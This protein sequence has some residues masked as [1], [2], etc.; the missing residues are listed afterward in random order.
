[1][2]DLTDWKQK[3][4][5]AH[6]KFKP[7][8]K[9][10]EK[11]LQYYRGIQPL[12]AS[13]TEK[14]VDNMVFSNIRALLP[15][16]NIRNPKIFVRA[17]KKPYQTDKGIFDTIGGSVAW[18]ILLAW[19]YQELKI[20]REARK[21]LVDSFLGP[22]GIMQLGYTVETEKIKSDELLE[23]NELIK[24]DSP[25]VV[26]RSLK[27]FRCDPE[28]TDSSLDDC[29][30]VAFRW[31]K[32]L[33]DLKASGKYSNLKTLRPNYTVKTD[34]ESKTDT[35]Q[36]VANDLWNRVEGWDI[37]DKKKHKIITIVEAHD[38]A[39]NE[40][41]W[42]LELEGFPCETLY[43]NENPDDLFPICDVEMYIPAQD[44][45][46][47]I[48]SLQMDY[49]KNIAQM[50]MVTRENSLNADQLLKLETGGNRTIVETSTNPVDAI[51]PLR[52]PSI[53]QDV[54][55][56]ANIVRKNLLEAAGISEAEKMSG[57]N[58]ET[59]SEPNLINAGVQSVREDQRDIFEDFVKRNIRKL[60]QIV[61][62]TMTE[63]SLPL[64]NE[65]F[66]LAQ[67]HLPTKLD[68][69]IGQENA[70]AIMPFL[71]LSKD[72]LQG[73]YDF[74]IELGSTQPINEQSRKQDAMALYQL[75]ASNPYMKKREGT[76]KLL[77]AFNQMDADDLLKTDE[78]VGQEQAQQAQMAFQ[79]Q[80]AEP[81]L[82]TQTDLQKTDMKTKTTLMGEKMRGDVEMAKMGH[83]HASKME[84]EGLKIKG[85]I[86]AE[87]LKQEKEKKNG[88]GDKD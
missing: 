2:S 62:Q 60:A 71:N 28:G 42:G 3:L 8:E 78:Q 35:V 83:E 36:D 37:W 76:L 80:M 26:R 29:N 21:C 58:F 38:K 73:E 72:D 75:L 19:Y 18:E 34:F 24:G 15:K 82:K 1:M 12:P 57:R 40:E 46:N 74:S 88:D 22:F 66:A 69:I 55:I 79:S 23:V 77:D 48:E 16:L 64:S 32:S 41:K 61:Q 10:V 20:R 7:I 4:S 13:Y 11:N 17:K 70:Q 84:H 67:K 14:V 59:A 50:I 5:V 53:A 52:T 6:R 56:V 81:Q 49:I 47:K 85:N 25:F 30:W 51:V 54:Y 86:L 68:K 27:D 44:V 45:L 31:V 63:T 33:D 39:L 43:F 87:A 9:K 65:Q